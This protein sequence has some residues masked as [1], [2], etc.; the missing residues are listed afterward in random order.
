MYLGTHHA[1][2][3][4]C[5]PVV[6]GQCYVQFS[7]ITPLQCINLELCF[8]GFSKSSSATCAVLQSSRS[9]WLRRVIFMMDANPPLNSLHPLPK[10]CDLSTASPNT[11][12]NWQW[13]SR[14]K[15]FCLYKLS[16]HK[17]FCMTEFP[18]SLPSHCTMLW[19]LRTTGIS[20]LKPSQSVKIFSTKL[21]NK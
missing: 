17:L 4:C 12:I 10:W 13:I 20:N 7:E 18:P 1:H 14:V 9:A 19:I 8:D 21:Q 3:H 15:I 2:T 11:N 16:H 5:I 6:Y